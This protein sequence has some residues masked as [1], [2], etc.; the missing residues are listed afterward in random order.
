M[1]LPELEKLLHT[2]L[3]LCSNKFVSLL[4]L[5]IIPPPPI[6]DP[7]N[8]SAPLQSPSHHNRELLDRLPDKG[9]KLK[10]RLDELE[11]AVA[12]RRETV[13][14][15]GRNAP[16]SAPPSLAAMAASL[17][18][19]E[20]PPVGDAPRM[21]PDATTASAATAASSAAPLSPRRGPSN[22][23]SSSPHTPAGPSRRP[24]PSAPGA[25]AVDAL[26]ENLQKMSL[27]QCRFEI[28][29]T[30]HVAQFVALTHA[31]PTSPISAEVRHRI[32]TEPPVASAPFD[33]DAPRSV[34]RRLL[35]KLDL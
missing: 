35:F 3:H 23:P 8:L 7:R 22:Q 12:R 1:A 17:V 24:D 30:A 5:V 14:E 19:Q 28:T 16:P 15:M 25:S 9:A 6:A 20:R 32:L 2:Q 13:S 33:K 29:N 18:V 21:A 31:R 26:A 10:R 11:D 4:A 27:S 34:V